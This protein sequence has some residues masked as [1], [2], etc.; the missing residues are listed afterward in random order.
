VRNIGL[1]RLGDAEIA[2]TGQSV[3]RHINKSAAKGIRRLQ[4]V[5]NFNALDNDSKIA[6][7]FSRAAL[8]LI[9]HQTTTVVTKKLSENASNQTEPVAMAVY[10]DRIKET[11]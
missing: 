9:H 1:K 11:L 8:G 3:I 2:N 10:L 5:K 7:N 6:H 4:S